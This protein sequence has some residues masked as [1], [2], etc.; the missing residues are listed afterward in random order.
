MK[1]T[2]SSSDWCHKVIMPDGTGQKLSA[3]GQSSALS[4]L[5]PRCK[6][7]QP[8]IKVPCDCVTALS[9]A[10]KTL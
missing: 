6:C 1:A 4:C 7:L 2:H 8:C 9:C 3:V 5:C 10:T